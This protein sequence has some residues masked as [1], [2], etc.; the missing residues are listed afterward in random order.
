[1]IFEVPAPTRGEIHFRLFDIPV[2]VH[3]YFWLTTLFMGLSPDVGTLL[4][5]IGVVFVSILWHE[6]G[7]VFAY[8]F[9][10]IHGDVVL[11]GFGGLAVPDREIRGTFARV[12]VS[13][14]GPCAGFLIAAAVFAY[15]FHA[16]VIE[17]PNYYES[18]LLRDLMWVNGFWGLVN[19]LPIYPLDG[20]QAARAL[21]EKHNAARGHRRSLIV[22]TAVAAIVAVLALLLRST[23][24]VLF[25]GS[26]AAA[27]A[28]ALEAD[29][30]LFRAGSSRVR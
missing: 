17:Y 13:A 9:F 16:P 23:Y 21:F 28:Q 14:A 5:W 18:L 24:M 7:H 15:Q 6:L 27:S 4:I 25:F 3:P 26:L 1:M 29:R 22:S 30:P 20:G 12:V 19:L 11:Y 10:G 2:R 8:R